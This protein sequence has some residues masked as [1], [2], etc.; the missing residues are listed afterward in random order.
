MKHADN[1]EIFCEN[2]RLPTI[3]H[4]LEED[5]K[6]LSRWFEEKELLINLKPG[7]TELLLFGTSQLIVKTNK[8]FKV[9]FNNQ[10][11]KET[12]SYKY[13]HVGVDYFWNLDSY[14]DKTYKKMTL[15]LRLLNKLRSHL[16]VFTAASI[17]NM[18]FV[19]LFSHCSLLKSKL[20]QTQLSRI[21]SFE[22]KTKEIIGYKQRQKKQINLVNIRKQK[23]CSFVHKLVM[24]EVN[25]RFKN[26]F[27]FLN[28]T[29]KLETKIF[30]SVFLS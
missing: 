21:L 13:L 2:D 16:M 29:T 3:E 23:I 14:F 26:Y 6:N 28:N 15:G 18:V 1:P 9:K 20:T 5:F 27:K 17:Y 25:D 19:P 11:V 8:N 30:Y 22:L 4:Q 7:K 10:Y 24:G 12:K